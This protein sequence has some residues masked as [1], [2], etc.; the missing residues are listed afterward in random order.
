MF[1]ILWASIE[2]SRCRRG[3]GK[4]K[5]LFHLPWWTTMDSYPG[6]ARW[7]A[8]K[9]VGWAQWVRL[10]Q[11]FLWF[12]ECCHWK[13]LL[14]KWSW[15]PRENG[16]VS[17]VPSHHCSPLDLSILALIPGSRGTFHMAARS[18]QMAILAPPESLWNQ[19]FGSLNGTLLIFAPHLSIH[20]A[21]A[22]TWS[23]SW[24]EVSRSHYIIFPGVKT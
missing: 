16:L 2:N 9:A 12:S 10:R 19:L 13:A 11:L 5:P 17:S 4:S 18:I 23:P 24:N 1:G 7:L 8:K 15:E 14:G 20:T 6:F 21:Y 3:E 22:L